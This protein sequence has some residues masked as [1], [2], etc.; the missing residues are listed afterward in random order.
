MARAKLRT[1]GGS[2]VVIEGDPN[3]VARIV[4]QLDGPVSQASIP[5][6]KK[7]SGKSSKSKPKSFTDHILLLKEEGFFNQPRDVSA[8]EARLEQDGQL[9]RKDSLRMSLIR[10]VRSRDL[11]RVKREGVWVYGKR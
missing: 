2:E 7:E 1:R 4:S 10:L 9:C 5:A 11:S 3:E 8:V 6:S